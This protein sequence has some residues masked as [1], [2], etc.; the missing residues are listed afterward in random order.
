MSNTKS[1]IF[2]NQRFFNTKEK[3]REREKL[4]G[5]ISAKRAYSKEELNP[6]DGLRFLDPPS[7]SAQNYIGEAAR[8]LTNDDK[9]VHSKY[10]NFDYEYKSKLGDG[11]ASKLYKAE[12]IDEDGLR[13]EV[14]IKKDS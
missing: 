8:S 11:S 3:Q 6:V 4:F 5:K 10:P 13:K 2:E 14:V 12:Y 9:I 1:K 7:C